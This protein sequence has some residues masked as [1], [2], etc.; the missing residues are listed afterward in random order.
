MLYEVITS[1]VRIVQLTG[2]VR[3]KLIERAEDAGLA[4]GVVSTARITHARNNFV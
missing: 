4:T 3:V 1:A 2:P